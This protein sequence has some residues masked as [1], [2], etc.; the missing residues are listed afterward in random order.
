MIMRLWHGQTARSDFEDYSRFMRER[1][2]PDYASSGETSDATSCGDSMTM[3][4]IS[5]W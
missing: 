5:F 1:A 4:R 2:A 3:R